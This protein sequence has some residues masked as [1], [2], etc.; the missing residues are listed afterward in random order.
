[1]PF[2]ST[3][4]QW[5]RVVVIW[6]YVI[7]LADTPNLK[8]VHYETTNSMKMTREVAALIQNLFARGRKFHKHERKICK[9]VIL[10]VR[11]RSLYEWTCYVR[12]FYSWQWKWVSSDDSLKK[13]KTPQFAGHFPCK[14]KG[15]DMAVDCERGVQ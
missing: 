14:L 11:Q 15:F 5:I 10:P 6:L 2:S 3:H 7:A 13:L 8:S 12:M 9:P 4:I 1:M